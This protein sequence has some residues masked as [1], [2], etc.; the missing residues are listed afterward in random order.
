MA[1]E[2]AHIIFPMVSASMKSLM[3]DWGPDMFLLL[4]V[5]SVRWFCSIYLSDV[6][7]RS[8]VKVNSKY[9]IAVVT[10]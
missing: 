2:V 5:C 8:K 10:G 9:R 1:G 6:S 3:K 7:L 4:S